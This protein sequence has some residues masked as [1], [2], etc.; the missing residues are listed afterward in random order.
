MEMFWLDWHEASEFG[1]YDILVHNV[2]EIVD[3]NLLVGLKM[4]INRLSAD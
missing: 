4:E 3:L 2:Q 1:K